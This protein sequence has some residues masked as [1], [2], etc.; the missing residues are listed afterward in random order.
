MVA[1]EKNWATLTI[2]R[3]M[4]NYLHPEAIREVIGVDVL[5]GDSDDVPLMVAEKIHEKSETKK[6][7]AEVV[8]DEKD[9]KGKCDRAKKRLNTLVAERMTVVR[10]Q[11]RDP[12]GEIEGWFRQIRSFLVI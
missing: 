8:S 2:K 5:F 12:S 9:C 10:L 3:E 6:P 7:W 11:E 4:E 1:E